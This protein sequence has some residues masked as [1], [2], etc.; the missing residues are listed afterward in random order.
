MG[1]PHIDAW[2]ITYRGFDD[3]PLHGWFLL[4]PNRE[5]KPAPCLVL[6]HGYHG[7]K[8][9]P[10]EYAAWLLMGFAVFAVDVRGQGGETGNQLASTHGMIS[11]WI[12]QNV[13]NK[14]TSYYLATAVDSVRALDWAAAQ[15]EVDPSRVAVVGAS[16]G[17]GLALLV[18]ALSP[19]PAV[20]VA[21]VPNM[22][23]MDYGILH[24]T[25]SLTELARFCN[26]NPD[27]L[28]DVMRTLSY[29][30]ILSH[31]ERIHI[32]VLVSVG[33]KD[34]VCLPETVFGAF[35]HLASA[36]KRI[37]VYP[38]SGHDVNR[39]A[40]QAARVFLYE[41]LLAKEPATN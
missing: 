13:L 7:S 40:K 38:F 31:A 10:E 18:S 16:Q 22:C 33:L 11:G 34:T 36:D 12:T 24:S 37:D 1:M 17:G 30:D 15:P 41:R 39:H 23:H 9:D 28:P 20:C 14:E 26:L 3:T 29:F 25:G 21:Q 2:K 5:D 4:P 32:P 8:G 27:R 6:Y 35:N 19:R